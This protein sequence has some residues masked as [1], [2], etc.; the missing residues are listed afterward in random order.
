M[1]VF[2]QPGFVAAQEG[3]FVSAEQRSELLVVLVAVFDQFDGFQEGDLVIGSLFG[4]DL[5]QGVVGDLIDAIRFRQY[6]AFLELLQD[7]KLLGLID[8]EGLKFLCRLGLFSAFQADEFVEHPF[9]RRV[10]YP[11]PL[12]FQ[13]RLYSPDLLAQEVLQHPADGADAVDESGG[14]RYFL[15]HNGGHFLIKNEMAALGFPAP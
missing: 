12:S 7:E 15:R 6:P 14:K 8:A 2:S 9:G 5:G 3:Q 1:L 13:R 11:P 4:D 10:R